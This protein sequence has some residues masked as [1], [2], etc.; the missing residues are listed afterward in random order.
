MEAIYH[1]GSGGRQTGVIFLHGFQTNEVDRKWMATF[2][3]ERPGPGEPAVTA[4]AVGNTSQETSVHPPQATV[5]G[6]WQEAAWAEE[7]N[8]GVCAGAWGSAADCGQGQ[9]G[10][11]WASVSSLAQ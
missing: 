2:G 7:G 6:R 9:S 1:S 8:E 11:L 10:P 5:L 3:S 4:Q